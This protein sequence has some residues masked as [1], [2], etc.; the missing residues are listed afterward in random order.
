M[1]VVSEPSD[2]EGTAAA[3]LQYYLSSR[4]IFSRHCTQIYS[5]SDVLYLDE[6]CTLNKSTSGTF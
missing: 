6:K 3:H 2:L 5:P 1:E 4:R